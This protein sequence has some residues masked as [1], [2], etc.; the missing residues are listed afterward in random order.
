[1]KNIIYSFQGKKS[2]S[3]FD[4]SVLRL[5]TIN[6]FYRILGAATAAEAEVNAEAPRSLIGIF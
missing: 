2:I 5:L 4:E 6:R 1:M 3:F